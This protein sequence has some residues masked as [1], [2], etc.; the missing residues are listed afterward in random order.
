[1]AKQ[2]TS[3]RKK[4]RTAPTVD[5]DSPTVDYD[6]SA[7]PYA[8]NGETAASVIKQRTDWS[9]PLKAATRFIINPLAYAARLAFNTHTLYNAHL[10]YDGI[11]PGQPRSTAKQPSDW[12]KQ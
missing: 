4:G 5:Y 10:T 11:V 3:W 2:T 7:T 1:M 6:G 9:K 12:S 8:G